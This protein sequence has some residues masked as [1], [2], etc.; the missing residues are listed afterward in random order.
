ML[1]APAADCSTV[2]R[3]RYHATTDTGLIR[4]AKADRQH[5]QGELSVS[6]DDV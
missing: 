1:F 4:C 5:N 6:L 2:E 3:A